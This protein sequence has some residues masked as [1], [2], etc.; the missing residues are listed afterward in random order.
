MARDLDPM[1]LPP[2]APPA[3]TPQMVAEFRRRRRS[4]N[5]A[6]LAA[7]AG[8]SVIIYAIVVVKLHEYGQMW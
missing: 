5:I 7:L 1:P 8:F 3:W 2:I 4:R 6:L